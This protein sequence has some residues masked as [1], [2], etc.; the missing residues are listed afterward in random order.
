MEY[1][2]SSNADKVFLYFI[3]SFP[4]LEFVYYLWMWHPLKFSI[5]ETKKTTV[6]KI[7]TQKRASNYDCFWPVSGL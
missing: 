3:F 7:L 6:K 4:F 1:A 2:Q 5:G